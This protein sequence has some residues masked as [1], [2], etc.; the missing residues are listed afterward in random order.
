MKESLFKKMKTYV[1][2][3]GFDT[4]HFFPLIVKYGIEKNDRIVLIRPENESEGQGQKAVRRIED[5]AKKIDKSIKIDV[6]KVN[7]LNFDSM[8]LS[9]IDLFESIDT[10][11]IANI[12]GGSRDVF[13]AFSIACLTQTAKI[14][15]V[16]NYS[17]VDHE[18][19]EVSLPHIV[20]S[21]DEK[22]NI[23]L[24][25]IVKH[26]PTIASEISGR[27]HISESTISRNLNKLKDL[28]AIDVD[29]KGKTNYISATTTGKIFLKIRN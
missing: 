28:K 16:T 8:L 21:L 15:K 24:E 18:L 23:L 6:Y 11:I 17:D 3:L 25:D 10:E 22:L 9:M 12:S 19:R 14:S 29:S 1:S 26:E 20:N 5:I 27:L 2:L 4:D 13:L 7:Y